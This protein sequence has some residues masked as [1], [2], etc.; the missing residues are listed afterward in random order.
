MP[1]VHYVSRALLQANGLYRLHKNDDGNDD[2][3]NRV[4]V[5]GVAP[6]TMDTGNN[7]SSSTLSES[8]PN[9]D[10]TVNN[11]GQKKK[12]NSR[13]C[14]ND[15]FEDL[16]AYKEKNGHLSITEKD[17]KSLFYWC[18]NIRSA[19]K[20]KLGTKLTTDGISA[21]DAI[22]FEWR[23]EG[24][25]RNSQKHISFQDRV[26][27]LSEYKEKNG[28]VNVS[29]KTD[30]SLYNWCTKIRSSRNKPGEGKLKLTADRITTLDAIGFDCRSEGLSRSW[31]KC[32]FARKPQLSSKTIIILVFQ[33][34]II[35]V[36]ISLPVGNHA[37]LP[38]ANGYG[39]CYISWVLLSS[40]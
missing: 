34:L 2:D 30:K 6:R 16:K 3:P 17:D 4:A 12:R 10:L 40:Q 31:I 21:L 32:P 13:V 9:S 36:E 29:R 35:L 5:T 20:G 14:F 23:S 28:H 19:R 1:T 24:I 37:Q 8:Q 7:S 33:L 15:S 39:Q 27:A 22:G 38:L 11:D 26:N 25:S 18:A